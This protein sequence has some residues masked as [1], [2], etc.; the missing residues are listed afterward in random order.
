[1][2][3]KDTQYLAEEETKGP[4]RI[5]TEYWSRVGRIVVNCVDAEEAIAT[6][7]AFSLALPR[8]EDALFLRD[9]IL[10][11][12]PFEKKIELL[13]SFA[14]SKKVYDKLLTK[15]INSAD[16]LRIIRNKL[17]HNVPGFIPKI[18]TYTIS[19]TKWDSDGSQKVIKIA[20]DNKL[21]KHVE[22]LIDDII[23]AHWMINKKLGRIRKEQGREIL[24]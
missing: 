19:Q 7:L 10:N 15:K 24:Y 5:T 13:R 23:E 4:Y 14:R 9:N 6:F 22:K 11:S 1:M 20:V 2:A 3:N 12:I 21:E 8:S 16:E 18:R 17:V